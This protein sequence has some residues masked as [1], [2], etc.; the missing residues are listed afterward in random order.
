[1]L[2]SNII[3]WFLVSTVITSVLFLI[4]MYAAEKP[5]SIKKQTVAGNYLSAQEAYE[6][7]SIRVRAY[8]TPTVYFVKK[9]RTIVVS[10]AILILPSFLSPNLFAGDNNGQQI[11]T[12]SFYK[13]KIEKQVILANKL[14]TGEGISQNYYR[15]AQL[16]T[17]ASKQGDAEAQYWLGVMFFDGL[18]ITDDRDDAM[19]WI[20]LLF[21]QGYAPAQKLLHHLLNTEEVLDC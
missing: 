18:G 17:E 4:P 12:A 6:F 7:I 20:A 1:M 10:T 13:T 9:L 5:Q 11:K 2:Y 19:H 3:K 14:R 8:R 15:A 21:D 16:Y